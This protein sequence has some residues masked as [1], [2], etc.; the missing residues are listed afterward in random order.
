MARKLALKRRTSNKAPALRVVSR[1]PTPL[2]STKQQATLRVATVDDGPLTHEHEEL[3]VQYRTKARKLG[4]SILRKWNV[5][6][7]LD[8]VDS[9]VD[10]SLCEAVRRFD[11]AKGA[12]FMTFLFYHLKGNLVRA[13]TTAVNLAAIPASFAAMI[14]G[15]SAGEDIK[16]LGVNAVDLAERL[17][18]EEVDSPDESLWKKELSGCSASA[19]EKLDPLEREIIKRIFVHEQQIIDIAAALGYSRCHISR[20]K[21]KA[22]STLYDEL[23]VSMNRDDYALIGN[24][25]EELGEIKGRISERKA[26]HRRRPRSGASTANAELLAAEAA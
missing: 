15:E 16:G 18:G 25:S 12:S 26:T 23:S 1:T 2:R 22:L 13:V 7:E 20:V 6:L 17:S 24:M 3:I 5:R 9:L 4:R 14:D 19:C 21:K 10:L 8:E 11:A